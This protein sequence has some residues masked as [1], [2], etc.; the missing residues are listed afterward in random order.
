MKTYQITYPNGKV[1]RFAVLDPKAKFTLRTIHPEPHV[2]SDMT[3]LLIR[4]A[5]EIGILE[6]DELTY[7]R[8][9]VVRMF[10]DILEYERTSAEQNSKMGEESKA[11]WKEY[12]DAMT[13]MSMITAVIDQEKMKRGMAI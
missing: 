4:C 7:V 8:N 10:S 11:H 5:L 13:R 3:A 2:V 9:E 6:D 12:D 1:M